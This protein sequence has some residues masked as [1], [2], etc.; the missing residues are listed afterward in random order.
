M[1]PTSA[2][3]S[4]TIDGAGPTEV[5]R[6][7]VGRRRHGVDITEGVDRSDRDAYDRDAVDR[8]LQHDC[9]LDGRGGEGQLAFAWRRRGAQVGPGLS[10]RDLA[11]DWM[12]ERLDGPETADLESSPQ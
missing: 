2:A 9:V 3:C 10:T 8:A 5:G 12:V 4:D 1:R 6:E 7:R 11:I